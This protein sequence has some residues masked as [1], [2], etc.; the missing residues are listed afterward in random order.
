MPLS[1][2]VV[3]ASSAVFQLLE[4]IF[5]V[6]GK[7]MPLERAH[8]AARG[9]GRSGKELPVCLW[10]ARFIQTVRDKRGTTSAGSRRGMTEYAKVAGFSLR[11]R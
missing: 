4:S 11:L 8:V 2:I 5:D 6:L 3:K 7:W 1:A 10:I 9:R